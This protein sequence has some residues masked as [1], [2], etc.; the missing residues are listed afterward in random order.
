LVQV[1]ILAADHGAGLVLPGTSGPD[2]AIRRVIEDCLGGGA[3]QDLD[4]ATGARVVVDRAPLTVLPAEDQRVIP[5]PRADE[6]ARVAAV[7]K[8]N[9]V[10]H[11]NGLNV[12]A[13]QGGG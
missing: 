6:V 11:L 12:A 3:A 13:G 10:R 5:G 2:V 7:G 8:A 9:E 1:G 4:R